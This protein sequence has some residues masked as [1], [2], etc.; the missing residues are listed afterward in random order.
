M[1]SDQFR[2]MA[3]FAKCRKFAKFFVFNEKNL[4]F[5]FCIYFLG[6]SNVHKFF[7]EHPT[8][9]PFS[10]ITVVFFIL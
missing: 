4:N 8:I 1:N 3:A 10:N 9:S 5:I 2:E 7:S 6:S